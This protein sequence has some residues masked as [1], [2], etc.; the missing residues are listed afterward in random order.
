MY[1]SNVSSDLLNADVVILVE[2]WLSDKSTIN[3]MVI[4]IL[5][6][7]MCTDLDMYVRKDFREA[8]N[9]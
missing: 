6:H 3:E 1:S 8:Y 5:H 7:T 2:T 9:F 4:L